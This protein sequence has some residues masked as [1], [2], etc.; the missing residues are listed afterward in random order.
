MQLTTFKVLVYL[1]VGSEIE[2]NEQTVIPAHTKN[3][4]L[5]CVFTIV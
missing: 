1:K 5:L 3:V 2:G 4:C